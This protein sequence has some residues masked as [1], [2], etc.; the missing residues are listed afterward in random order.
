MKT[1]K[2]T[3]YFMG[4]GISIFLFLLLLLGSSKAH[5]Q[6]PSF[7]GAEGFGAA[8]TGGRG[9]QVIYVTNLNCSGPGSL[10]NALSIPGPKYILFTVS[11]IIDCAAEIIEGDC[12]LAGQT[13]PDGIIVRGIIAD[14]YYTPGANPNNVIIRHIRSRGIGD[15]PCPNNATDPII[16]SGVENM[17]VDHCSF[18]G[19]EDEAAD[20]SRTSK[21][22]IQN[23]LLAET[24]GPHSY[25]GG[26]LLNYL[27]PGQEMDSISVHHNNWNRL[28]G[29]LPEISCEDPTGCIN[30]L[31]HAEFSNNLIWDQENY[32]YYNMDA[33]LSNGSDPGFVEP[34]NLAI[35]F[36]NN[37]AVAE[38]SY[39]G[40]MFRIDYLLNTGNQ[41]FVSNNQMNLYPTYSDYELF[42]CCSDFCS[43]GNNP[44]TNMGT[45]T[46]LASEHNYPSISLIAPTDLPNYMVQNVGA[47]PRFPHENRL[48]GYVNLGTFDPAPLNVYG[49]DDLLTLP[50]FSNTA[51][52]DTDQ[53]GMPD[54]WENNHG[55]NPNV[56][57]HNGTN[58]SATITGINGYTNLECYLNCLADALV[59]GSAPACQI[60]LG[61]ETEANLVFKVYPNPSSD[62]I[63]VELMN[64]T[65]KQID[66]YDALGKKV[67][68]YPISGTQ[69]E[70]NIKN[71]SAGMYY[72]KVG[73]YAE[74]II[75]N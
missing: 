57:D 40:P 74:T 61:I 70:I 60:P 50:V 52:T 27:A 28:G 10:N 6:I 17:V 32:I 56:P 49:V 20:I 39:C 4:T 45:A 12:Y 26:M 3:F 54:Y 31:L 13:S 16:I 36:E 58:L 19:S 69:V 44:N 7:P 72:I 1:K 51:P 22:T 8:T 63:I 21:L 5:S 65:N 37:Y 34:F 25:L 73:N 68:T 55:L 38:T 47:F 24:I 11:G 46:L 18:S 2:A 64:E 30:H 62:F 67:L 9:G 75:K 71:L 29:R 33:D 66:L 41:L 35:N 42:Y 43:V 59:S 14:D 15:H 48:M 53:D 23:C